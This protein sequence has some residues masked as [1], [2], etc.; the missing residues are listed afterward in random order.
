MGG[1]QE[2]SARPG[3]LSAGGVISDAGL[4]ASPARTAPHTSEGGHGYV[5]LLDPAAR[6]A[7]VDLSTPEWTRFAHS[8][9]PEGRLPRRRR[10][11]LVC[12]AVRAGE[13]ARPA[14]L[15]T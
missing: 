1:P 8:L 15:M 9:A 10:P 4:A 11:P 3:R 7:G 5:S 14:S 2:P 13:A 12:G 6:R